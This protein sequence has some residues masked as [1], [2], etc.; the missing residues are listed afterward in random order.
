MIKCPNGTYPNNEN[1]KKCIDEL[2]F[3]QTEQS[4]QTEQT[5]QY[6]QF[7]TIIS[8]SEKSPYLISKTNECSNNCTTID[9][10]NR[11]CITGYSDENI[12]ENNIMNIISAITNHSIES[13]LNNILKENGEEVIINENGIIYQITTSGYQNNEEYTTNISTIKLGN[14]ENNLKK[15][16][17]INKNESLLIFK[18]DAFYEGLLS[19]IVIYEIYHPTTKERL[20][21]NYCKND[22]INISFPVKINESEL[23]KYNQSNEFY[24]DI[25]STY[26]SESGTDI[27]INDRQDE[28][29]N[30]NLSLCEDGC[31][32]SYYDYR[33]KKANCECLTK[34]ELPI[35]SEIMIDKEKLRKNFLDIKNLINLNVMKCYKKL[36]SK[37]G[38]I[39]NIGSYIILSIIFIYFINSNIFCIKEYNVLLKKFENIFSY[40]KNRKENTKRNKNHSDS[41]KKKI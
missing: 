10:I 3:E 25:C 30:N 38:I 8:C 14:C 2:N 37:E 35:F 36:F 40:H 28:F 11:Y 20:D 21:L 31:K 24:N 15:H 26:T 18:V 16:Y 19:P 17:K 27:T 22:I 34:L 1:E 4:E 41:L 9:W 6:S 7:I 23:F 29:I 13:L 32:F 5:E 12:K 33:T 39:K